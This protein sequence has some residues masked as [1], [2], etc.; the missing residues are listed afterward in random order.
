M[1]VGGWVWGVQVAGVDGQPHVPGPAH[2]QEMVEA[3]DLPSARAAS[4]SQLQ[5]LQHSATHVRC[6]DGVLDLLVAD[7]PLPQRRGEIE[8]FV[9]QYS[10]EQVR[11]SSRFPISA[12][13]FCDFFGRDSKQK[14]PQK[15]CAAVFAQHA[16]QT[17]QPGPHEEK[18]PENVE[19]GKCCGA[20]C[21]ERTP[22][23]LQQLQSRIHVALESLAAAQRP[24]AGDSKVVGV[25]ML[26]MLIAETYFGS[27]D[28]P[29]SV[30]V[31]LLVDEHQKRGNHEAMQLLA[32][33]STTASLKLLESSAR[34]PARLAFRDHVPLHARLEAHLRSPFLDVFSGCVETNTHDVWSARVLDT[35]GTLEPISR[36]KLRR[37][38]YE[39][40]VGK[41]WCRKC[42][43]GV[44]V[45]INVLKNDLLE[46]AR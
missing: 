1:W 6:P 16:N 5:L 46:V 22:A 2:D 13:K 12:K 45:G 3:S 4:V 7:A 9:D 44:G 28:E 36:V 14:N 43:M 30:H 34:F 24:R 19:Y 29:R 10:R 8:S 33:I 15:K 32:S 31:A 17:P 18:F 25:K 42:A 21:S 11:H 38:Q 35:T 37:L 20:M 41:L 26:P 23:R 27:D 39:D 40:D